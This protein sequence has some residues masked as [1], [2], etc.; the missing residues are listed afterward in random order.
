M[1]RRRP[2]A[3]S[4]TS[5]ATRCSSGT[6]RS[7]SGSSAAG[8][9]PRSTASTATWRPGAGTRWPTTGWGSPRATPGPSPTPIS[10]RMVCQAANALVELGVKAGDRVAIYMPM[11]PETVVA[12]LACARLGAPHSVIFGGFSA[13]ALAGRILDADAR[14]V[15]TADGGY[16]RGRRPPL[17]VNVDEALRAVPGRPQRARG[18]PDR[19]GRGLG[20]RAGTSGG[21]TSSTASRPSTSRSPSTPSSRSTSCTRAARR[22][23]PRAS[24]TRPAAT[25][26]TAPPPTGC[27]FDIKPEH[28]RLL[29]GGRRRLGHRPQLH[30]LRA[31]GQR[32]HLGHVRGDARRRRPGPLV[33][34]RRGLQGLDPLHRARPPSAP[35]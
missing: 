17:K 6:S 5:P 3:S 2:S 7:P 8:S 4:G 11:I 1:G 13:E 16:R 33:A 19:P 18:P 25:S 12:M 26:S 22:P 27:I 24:C 20:R 34:D 35:S 29:D 14:I 9:T 23:S 15:I 30:R 31:A 10:T 32:D 28:G 21:T